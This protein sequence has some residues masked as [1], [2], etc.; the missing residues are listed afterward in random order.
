MLSNEV[1][2]IAGGAGLIGKEYTKALI[3]QNAHVIVY[4]HCSASYWEQQQIQGSHFF[5]G[6]ITDKNKLV[7]T[8]DSVSL[9]YGKI[10]SFV[11]TSF[12]KN[13]NYGRHF[14]EVEFTD[15]VEDLSL[16]MGGYFIAAQVAADYFVKQGYGNIIN[17]ASIYGVVAPRFEIYENTEM[18]SPV[19]YSVIKAGII[20]FTKYMAKYFKGNN[21][22]VNSISPGGIWDN[23]DEKFVDAYYHKCLSK[24][25]LDKTD[26]NGALIFLLSDMSKYVNGQ[27]IVVDDGFTL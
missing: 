8:L 14:F 13:K 23:Q 21:I 1:I 11:N 2:I 9:K 17:M 3:K 6:D 4:D 26:L 27:N 7:K 24:G 10:D 16:H 22:R 25:M 5:Q 20:H 19:V 15:F 12:P 18:T